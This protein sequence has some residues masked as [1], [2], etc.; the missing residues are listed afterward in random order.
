MA[1]H[2]GVLALRIPGTGE[3]GGLL[4]MGSHGVGHDRSNLAAA[5]VNHVSDKRLVSAIYKEPLHLNNKKMN[6]P[7]QKWGKFLNRYF[8]EENIHML[9]KHRQKCL[10][11]LLIRKLQTET[12]V[13]Y[14][15][16]SIRIARVKK[17]N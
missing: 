14:H 11:S 16:I 2:S 4:S 17:S 9:N 3:P 8:F 5:L 13:N 6:D 10:T 7:V 1:P 12:T 15:S